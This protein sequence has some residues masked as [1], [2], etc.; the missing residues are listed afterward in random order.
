MA[1]SR[2]SAPTRSAPAPQRRSA[3]AP[4]PSSRAP[5]PPAANHAPA[6]APS[7]SMA[8]APQSG[9]MLSGLA[10][11][12]AQ[13]FAFGTGSAVARTAVDSFM[14]GGR[15]SSAP[16]QNQQPV[17]EAPKADSRYEGPAACKI[18]YQAFNDC[19]RA[20]TNNASACE[21]YFNSYKS[22]QQANI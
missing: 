20:N 17:I 1:R 18:D 21:F 16:E 4:A 7:H 14:G 11:T 19:L 2:S 8:P 22:C 5:P 15:S 13:G 9:G 3:P 6:P 12:M 10:S